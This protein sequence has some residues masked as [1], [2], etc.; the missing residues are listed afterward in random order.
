MINNDKSTDQETG[1]GSKLRFVERILKVAAAHVL[2][3][4]AIEKHQ[5]D[6]E[7]KSKAERKMMREIMAFD[8]KQNGCLLTIK[9]VGRLMGCGKRNNPKEY[10]DIVTQDC[11]KSVNVS[12]E[13]VSYWLRNSPWEYSAQKSKGFFMLPPLKR[14]LVWSKT[15]SE[16]KFVEF[17]IL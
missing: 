5:E 6:V 15:I 1:G 17:E 12:R 8:A 9:E 2:M 10:W 13:T 16:G 7:R 4:E 14:I 3:A 11:H